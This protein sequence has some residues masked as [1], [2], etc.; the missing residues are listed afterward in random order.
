M[1]GDLI[2]IGGSGFDS[3]GYDL[4]ALMT[5]SE[6]MLG[7]IVEI[8]VKLL[9]IP[10]FAQVILAAFDDI[11]KA[12]TAVGDIIAAGIVPAGLEMMDN[13]SIRA[14][15][16]FVNA[17]YPV[18]AA[19]IVLCEMD[20][21]EA[22]VKDQVNKVDALL[23]QAGATMIRVSANDAEREL[24]WKGRKAAFPA[25]GRISP[26]YY[27]TAATPQCIAKNQ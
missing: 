3:A 17:G 10:E 25:V 1:D 2:S 26:D 5:G 8:T 4:L 27:S 24:I 14:S 16:A 6:G 18:E 7:V 13:P 11:V 20:G 15:E 9:P 12:G 23:R 19:A 21:S 22:E